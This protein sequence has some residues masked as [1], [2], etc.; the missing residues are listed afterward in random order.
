MSD[1]VVFDDGSLNVTQEMQ[2]HAHERQSFD[3]PV[4]NL[5]N[6]LIRGFCFRQA[7]RSVSN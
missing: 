1:L 4:V 7:T 5:E 3:V 6:P 2:G